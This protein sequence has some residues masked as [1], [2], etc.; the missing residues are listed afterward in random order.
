[1]LENLRLSFFEELA[2]PVEEEPA[3]AEARQLGLE[4]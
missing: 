2:V 3:G 1:V 4:M